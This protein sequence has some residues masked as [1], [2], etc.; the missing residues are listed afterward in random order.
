MPTQLPP[1]S[2][3]MW[4]DQ[5]AQDLFHH[6]PVI[7]LPSADPRSGSGQRVAG[8][9]LGR[10][11]VWWQDTSGF[12]LKYRSSLQEFHSPLADRHPVEHL[13][14]LELNV[15]LFFARIILTII[16]RFV[17]AFACVCMC[18]RACMFTGECMW[19]RS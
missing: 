3:G 14:R 11:E 10:E 9:M 7:F 17:C 16:N 13:Y 19:G 18:D 1:Y 2:Y 5:A 4:F 6:H 12:F 8:R 15:L